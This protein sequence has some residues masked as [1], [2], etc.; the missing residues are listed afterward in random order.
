VADDECA[1]KGDPALRA[2]D[3]GQCFECKTNAHCTVDATKPVC[4]AHACRRCNS[5]TEC[6]APG[7]CLDDGSCATDAHVVH[8]DASAATCPGDGSAAK[9]FCSPTDATAA[10]VAPKTVLVV[11]GPNAA[12]TINTTL[13]LV[14]VVG[15]PDGQAAAAFSVGVGAGLTV[16]GGNVLARDLSAIAGTLSS[17]KGFLVTGAGAKLTLLRVTSAL[18]PGPGMGL[19]VDAE[20]GATLTMDRCIVQNN[21][22][23]G[24]LV[25]GA[26]AT[27]T[28][29]VFANNGYGVKFNLP[30]AGTTFESNTVVGN[31]IAATCDSGHAQPLIGSIIVGFVD[32]C[33]PIDS[34]PAAPTF[35]TAR[36]FHLTMHDPCPQGDPMNMMFP[37]DDIDGDPRTTAIDCGADQYVAK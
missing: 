30:L 26:A 25:N 13:P 1:A 24:L 28:N 7:I 11:H 21:S 29:S 22:V 32:T 37:P 12:V 23:G 31:S 19:G 33:V 35:D 36:P 4:D 9:P 16:S 14:V 15:K 8:L 10:L 34:T 6:P 17:S 18:G 5:D 2:C 27:V 20:S 3:Q